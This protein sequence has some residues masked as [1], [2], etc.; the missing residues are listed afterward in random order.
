MLA[1]LEVSMSSMSDA[2]D[3]LVELGPQ[4]IAR[5][6]ES[7]E[8][9]WIEDALAATGTASIR[10]RKLPAE[11]A[12]WLVLGMG[13]FE[14]RSIVDVVDHLS[15]VAPGVRSLA[16]SSIPAARYRLGPEPVKW[17]FDKVSAT[18]ARTP[19]SPRHRGL[20]LYGVDGSHLRVQD[21]DENFE[22]F[23]K[24]GGRFGSG[25]SGYPQVRVAC[26]LN[27]NNRLLVDARFGTMEEGE[28]SIAAGLWPSVP[29]NSLTILDRGF[30][31]YRAFAELVGGGNNRHLMIRM[32]SNMKPEASERLA[33]GSLLVELRPR[34][35]LLKAD[36]L[37]PEKLVGRVI[38]YKHPD[39]VASR[40]FVTM[41]NPAE[42]P[43]K[44]LVE[45]YH[46]R[47]ELE[48]AYDELKTHMLE[49]RESLRS[50]KP[51]GVYQELWG[52]LLTYNLVRREMLLV[53]EEHKLAP[54]RI[55]FWSALLWIRNFWVMAWR[56][57]TGA[58]PR[59]LGE[60][61]SALNV[62]ILPERR[63]ERRYPRHVKIKMSNYP[64][65]RGKRG[66]A[67]ESAAK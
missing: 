24:P 14:D 57:T 16:P 65:N 42:Y 63:P 27:L 32:T 53:A 6:A 15:L 44:E 40:L 13:L 3:A 45:L 49:R 58:I 25:D 31:N 37:L 64:R 67:P 29:D 54:Q 8:P 18:W 23:G 39:G 20:A 34:K 62:L 2:L 36:P 35:K 17:L 52:L 12:I 4:G 56:S 43:A 21:S 30:I 61:R 38:E 50:K 51:E 47:W 9:G 19:G 1:H 11:Q 33:D 55:S 66:S 10:R 41:T 46:E 26:L 5:F 48:V 7:L 60:L 28:Q 22:H 59:H